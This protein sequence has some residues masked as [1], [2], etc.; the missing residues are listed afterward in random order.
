M[1]HSTRFYHNS[2][3]C[4][5][6]Q[7]FMKTL[8]RMFSEQEPPKGVL[9]YETVTPGSMKGQR[10]TYIECVPVEWGVWE[11]LGGYFKVLMIISILHVLTA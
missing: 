5:S 11:A 7:N 8:M 4:P 6:Q 2:L 3:Y 1:Y 9:F 10:H